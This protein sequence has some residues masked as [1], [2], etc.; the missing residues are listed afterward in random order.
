MAVE[1]IGVQVPT[2]IPTLSSD[3]DI[4]TALRIYHY[5][6][7]DFPF[8]SD[9]ATL[10]TNSIAGRLADLDSR[11][12]TISS[13]VGVDASQFQQKGDILIGKNLAQYDNLSVGTDGYILTADSTANLGVSWKILEV[14]QSNQVSLSN[15][16]LVSPRISDSGLSILDSSGN[17]L[18]GFIKTPSAIN[19]ITVTNAATAGKPTISATGADTNITLN[20]VSKGTGTVQ[21]N[22][23]D[24]VTTT[25]TQTLTNKTISSITVNGNTLSF[26][27]I[28]GAE[29]VITSA[30]TQTITNKSLDFSTTRFSTTGISLAIGSTN[31]PAG[32]STVGFPTGLSTSGTNVFV[33]ENTSQTLTNKTLTSPTIGTSILGA[34]GATINMFTSNI[35]LLNIGHSASTTTVNGTFKI[36]SSRVFVQAS[37]PSGGTYTNGDIWIKAG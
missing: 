17:E 24:V 30:A 9:S 32:T 33:F 29:S 26:P 21:A 22:G 19:E 15:K 23:V 1:D 35:S 28:S 27:E 7:E 2:K 14:T 11:L 12:D 31:L 6:S 18:I 36:G 8:N 13:T 25:G 4:Q 5:G 16:T 20:L 37:Q 3:A 10:I 34:S